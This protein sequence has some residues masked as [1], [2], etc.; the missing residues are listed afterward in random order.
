M[1]IKAFFIHVCLSLIFIVLGLQA[2]NDQYAK[3][4]NKVTITSETDSW[5]KVS[6]PFNIVTHPR[7]DNFRGSRPSTIEEAF[8]PEFVED[9]KV[10]LY[11]CFSNEFKKRVLRSSKMMDSQFYQYYRAD[12]D[13]KI[14]KVDRNTKYA[15]FMFPAAVAEKDEFGSSYITPVGYAIEILMEGMPVEI[16]NSIVFDK[17]RDEATLLKFKQQAEEKSTGNNGVLVP[18]HYVFPSYFQ[19]GAYLL[20]LAPEN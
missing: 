5:L 12:I 10:R 11:I 9:V 8:N 17:Y 19:K 6:V 2:Q 7:I 1:S 3:I 14:L 4:T 20:P 15:N 18:A 13:F 16:S